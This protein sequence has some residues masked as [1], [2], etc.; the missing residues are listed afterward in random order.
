MADNFLSFFMG[1]KKKSLKVKL[2]ADSCSR[3]R[4]DNSVSTLKKWEGCAIQ[5]NTNNKQAG[6]THANTRARARRENSPRCN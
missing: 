2:A 4:R 3:M 5:H 6:K 1:G